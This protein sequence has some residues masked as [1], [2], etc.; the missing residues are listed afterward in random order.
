MTVLME[1]DTMTPQG[2]AMPESPP[3]LI[4]SRG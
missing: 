2:M 3:E 1:H 4:L